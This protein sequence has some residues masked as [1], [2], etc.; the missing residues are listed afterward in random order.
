MNFV[1]AGVRDEI[2]TRLVFRLK[3]DKPCDKLIVSAVDS[4]QV[5]IDGE[6][7]SYGPERTAAN[8]SRLR[9]IELNNKVKEIVIY[10]I[11][12]NYSTY[13]C[14]LQKPFF[15]AFVYYK[16]DMRYNTYDFDCFKDYSRIDKTARYSAQRGF[17]ERYDFTINKTERLTT[18]DVESPILLKGIG[19]NHSYDKYTFKKVNEGEFKGFSNI[20]ELP[21][22]NNKWNQFDELDFDYEKDFLNK[23]SVEQFKEINYVLG[24]EHSGFIE[25]DLKAR[26]ESEVFIVFD[27]LM[28]EG[29]WLLRRDSCSDLVSFK[30]NKGDK[31]FISAEPYTIRYLKII[32]NGDVDFSPSVI[33]CENKNTSGVKISGNQ[34]IVT[35]FDAAKNTFCQNATDIFMDCPGR[36]RAGWLCD[37]YFTGK[38]EM[39][40]TGKNEIEKNFLENIII[41]D[42]PDVPYGMIPKCF[43]SEHRKSLYIPNWAMWFAI[44]IKEYYERTGD[45]DLVERAKKK[46]YMV[47]DFFKK[48]LNEYSLLENLESWVFI[49]WSIANDKSYIKGVNFPSNMLYSYMLK[50]IANL[51]NDNSL[52]EMSEKMQTNILKLSYNG[53]FFIDNAERNERGELVSCQNH[54]S[55]TCQYY[56]LFTGLCPDDNFKK[57]IIEN[58]GPFRTNAYPEVGKSNVFIGYYLRLFW[59]CDLGEYERVLKESI[60]YF[61]DMAEKTGTL[62]EKDMPTAS[63]NHGFASVAAV[64]I[65][66]C[67]CGYEGVKNNKPILNTTNNLSEKYSVKIEFLYEGKNNEKTV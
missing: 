10:V 28:I 51:Y 16:N 33:A 9:E 67:L 21:W 52:L 30:L 42:T 43:P 6:F 45:R 11:G 7:V 2:N 34:K 56:A 18:Y 32:Y 27:E 35:I 1:W 46:L 63:C 31:N 5:F 44:E 19:D 12:Y 49:E 26:S 54:I 65:L 50:C 23:V 36:E 39:L 13:C 22:L 3:V 57:N 24:K 58:F 62:W 38:A 55:E 14:D 64:I 37:S 61:Y 60:D 29:S 53:L 25:I 40:F 48:Y 41:A 20:R 4:Y 15:G 66:K 17:I 8:Y 59:L 47:I